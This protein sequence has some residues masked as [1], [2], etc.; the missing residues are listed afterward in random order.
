MKV[1]ICGITRL[2]DAEIVDGVADYAGF[3]VDPAVNNRRRIS[4]DKARDLASVLSKA[5]PVLVYLNRDAYMAVDEAA[6][7]GFH[8]VQHHGLLPMDVY[9]YAAS[10]GVRLAPVATYR[11]QDPHDYAVEVKSLLSNDP[12]YVLVDAEKG[13]ERRYEHGLKVP[14][15]V[16]RAV[17]G[18]GRVALAGGIGPSNVDVVKALDPY[19]I[20]VSSGVEAEPG[21]KDPEKVARLIA[22]LP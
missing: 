16:Y 3:I 7:Y 5:V 11:G 18:L 13:S 22:A 17:A 4:L 2:E 20:D 14:L 19:M 1:K 15:H 12:E 10:M 21:V 9:E 6:R 8:V